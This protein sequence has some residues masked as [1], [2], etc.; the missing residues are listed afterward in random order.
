MS[1]PPRPREGDLGIYTPFVTQR[2]LVT[3]S[4]APLATGASAPVPGFVDGVKCFFGGLGFLVKTPGAWPLALVPVV[5]VLL[6]G[7]ALCTLAVSYVPGWAGDWMGELTGRDGKL[8]AA[9]SVGFSVLVTVIAVILAVFV[10]FTLSQPISGPAFEALVRRQEVDLGL[11]PRPET[12]FLADVWLALKS[13]ILGLAIAT[14]VLAVLFLVGFFFPP[15]QVVTIPL[16]ILVA[17]V[18]L[19]WDVCDVPLGLRGIGASRR[20]GIL[21]RHIGAVFGMATGVALLAVVPCGILLAMP[22][23]VIGAARLVH[24]IEQAEGPLR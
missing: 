7:G 24:A 9:L 5:V 12:S 23:G 1:P 22:I 13:S 4:S 15:A 3:T 14:P 17:V 20:V 2:P 10:A 11:P 6:L 19:A 16:K 8:D 21:G 18:V